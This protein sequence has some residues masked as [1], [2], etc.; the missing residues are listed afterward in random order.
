[1]TGEERELV[2]DYR[3][4]VKGVGSWRGREGDLVIVGT[5]VMGTGRCIVGM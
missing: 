5:S 4:W 2:Y 3:Q 1:M